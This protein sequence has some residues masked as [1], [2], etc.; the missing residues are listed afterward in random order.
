MKTY[1]CTSCNNETTPS[2]KPSRNFMGFEKVLCRNCQ[3]EFQAPLTKSYIVI[4][5]ILLIGIIIGNTFNAI[6]ISK[7]N[8]DI[9]PNPVGIIVIGCVIY[10]LIKNKRLNNKIKNN[11]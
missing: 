1:I 10:A 5:W 8:M 6:G 9:R 4:S 11:T 2:S 3:Q 7:E